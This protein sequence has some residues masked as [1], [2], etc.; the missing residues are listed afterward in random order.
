MS[1]EKAHTSIRKYGKRLSVLGTQITLHFDIN[2][3]HEF[4]T[5]VK[6]LRALLRWLSPVKK[7]LTKSFTKM[8]QVSGE[9][10]NAQV[11]LK[12][13]EEEKE[14]LTG[15]RSWLTASIT[16][17]EGQWYKTCH[18]SV[19]RRLRK[20]IERPGYKKGNPEQLKRFC[21]KRVNR[22][23]GILYL[24]SPPDEE[25][26]K[27]RKML[28]DMQ[29]VYEWSGNED[30]G[31][32]TIKRIGK[33]AGSFNDRRIALLLLTT[34]ME[35]E[36]PEGACHQAAM[37]IKGKWEES[38]EQQKKELIETLT[39]FVRGAKWYEH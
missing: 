39:G 19:I 7:P 30:P 5:T 32:E 23:E 27:A 33:Q 9:L 24:S 16:R 11:L 29:Y 35:E 26:H 31:L 12:D 10:R 8:Y 34:Y 13:M 20:K 17:L 3:I 22:I 18:P 6:K 36:R 4:R 2:S 1:G 14:E 25:L 38:R 21:R 28:K 15:F 37:E